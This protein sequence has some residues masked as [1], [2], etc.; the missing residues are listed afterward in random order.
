MLTDLTHRRTLE[1]ERERA[2]A[3]LQEATR[4]KDEFLGMLAHELRN[5][6]APIL[7]GVEV[8]ENLGPGHEEL[9]TSS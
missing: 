2:L 4:H 5:P 7:N 9:A 6:L 3:E 8:L 1:R